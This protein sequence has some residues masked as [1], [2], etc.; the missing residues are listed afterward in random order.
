ME[1]IVGD[2][3]ENHIA[4]RPYD[5]EELGYELSGLWSYNRMETDS[6]IIYSAR[7]RRRKFGMA[8]KERWLWFM[9][10]FT[11]SNSF[12]LL[13]PPMDHVSITRPVQNFIAVNDPLYMGNCGRL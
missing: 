5:E 7:D 1:R 2:K 10:L 6:R 9:I 3:V 4:E 8:S 13:G 11:Y 12:W